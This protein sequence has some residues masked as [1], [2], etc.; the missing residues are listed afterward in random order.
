MKIAPRAT[1]VSSNRTQQ[2]VRN[3]NKKEADFVAVRR[4]YSLTQL[5]SGKVIDGNHE[6]ALLHQTFLGEDGTG[7]PVNV[8]AVP[9]ETWSALLEIAQL[10]FISLLTS[11]LLFLAQPFPI[12]KKE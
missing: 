10:F 2:G 9:R 4:T 6:P 11:F 8:P 5:D 7:C 12:L 3:Q 1:K